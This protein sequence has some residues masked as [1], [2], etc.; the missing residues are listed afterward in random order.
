MKSDEAFWH[1]L[2]RSRITPEEAWEAALGLMAK[3]LLAMHPDGLEQKVRVVFSNPE[4]DA[5]HILYKSKE[6]AHGRAHAMQRRPEDFQKERAERL[7]WMPEV[8]LHPDA[9]YRDEAARKFVYI[10]S[11]LPGEEYAVVVETTPMR[12]TRTFV[13]AYPLDLN[14]W[15]EQ[16]KRYRRSWPKKKG[17]PR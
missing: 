1:E 2:L 3:P 7:L 8:L 13:T 6:D 10:R 11:T 4:R 17:D 12:G 5:D 9:V 16:R 15:K 14:L